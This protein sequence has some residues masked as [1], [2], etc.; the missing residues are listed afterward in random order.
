MRSGD[1]CQTF[2]NIPGSLNSYTISKTALKRKVRGEIPWQSS[3]Q[4]VAERGQVWNSPTMYW[5]RGRGR[6]AESE[7]EKCEKLR[8]FIE[9]HDM[10][11]GG[12]GAEKVS[13]QWKKVFGGFPHNGN[14]FRKIFHTMEAGF[15][16][17]ST[18]WN[19]VSRG[20]SMVWKSFPRCGKNRAR[21]VLSG[22]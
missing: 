17:F 16:H 4:N 20:F 18:Q 14:M 8:D 22:R 3:C 12:R 13:T 10:R 19:H 6:G 7:R 5:G 2:G 15:G 1:G 9:T 21:P 11:E